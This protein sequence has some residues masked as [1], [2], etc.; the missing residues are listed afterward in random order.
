MTNEIKSNIIRD[1]QGIKEAVDSHV[2]IMAGDNHTLNMFSCWLDGSYLGEDHYRQNLKR[3]GECEGNRKKLRSFVIEQFTKYI[4][5]DA[6]CSYGYA[7]KVI[8]DYLGTELLHS[9]NSELI[10]Y[11][12]E[13][14]AEQVGEVA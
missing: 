9:L 2:L 3:I 6:H 11:V 1:L 4:A 13:F 12:T 8:V 7:Q 5:H 10:D 14:H